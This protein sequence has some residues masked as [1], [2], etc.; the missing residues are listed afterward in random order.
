MLYKLRLLFLFI[1]VGFFINSCSTLKSLDVLNLLSSP[2]E[3]G[4]EGKRL[5][6][7]VSL[8]EIKINPDAAKVPISLNKTIRNYNWNQKGKNSYNSPENLI[9]NANTNLLWKKDIGDGEGKYNKIY[10]QPVG[11][12]SFIY[13]L[14]SEGKL[15][16]IDLTNGNIIWEQEIFPEEESIN[17]NID[18]GLA[19]FEDSL[20]ISSSYGEIIKI[21]AINGKIIWKKNI[22]RPVQ[23]APTINNELIYQMTVNNEL[24]VLDI[25]T[26]TELW[27]YS[28]SHV[29]AISNGS[30]APAVNNDI[31]IFP[32]NTGEILALDPLTGSLIWNSSLVIEGAISGSLELTDIDSGPVINDGLVFASSLSGKFAVLD[33]ISGT[34]LWEVPIKTSSDAIV[35][36]DSVFITSND[37]RVI[38]LIKNSGEVRWISNISET[39]NPK[40]DDTPVCSTPILANDNIILTCYDGSVLKIDSN[41]GDYIKLFKLDS[42]I[43]ISPIIINEHI[44]FYTEDAEIVVYR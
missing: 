5:D 30:S 41:S 10:A 11:N 2:D 21:N 14:D 16:S 42:P 6:I 8:K 18:G 20:I 43:F 19:L 1:T 7:S 44:I 27:R 24:Y 28:A 17:S 38:N 33:L 35:N 23:G 29:S 12:K 4:I 37:G 34:L 9:V 22:Y 36:G 3:K 26:G 32:S 15:V 40:S 39:I 31:V 25:L 13:A